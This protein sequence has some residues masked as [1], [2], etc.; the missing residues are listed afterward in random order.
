MLDDLRGATSTDTLRDVPHLVAD[1][2]RLLEELS[3][4]APLHPQSRGS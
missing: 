3:R 1:I 4:E 2:D